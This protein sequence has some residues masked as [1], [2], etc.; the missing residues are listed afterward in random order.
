MAASVVVLVVTTAC[1][2]SRGAPSAFR[3]TSQAQASPSAAPVVPD[4]LDIEVRSLSS[5][6]MGDEWELKAWGQPVPRAGNQ[7]SFPWRDRT[8]VVILERALSWKVDFGQS[9]SAC[10][11]SPKVKTDGERLAWLEAPPKNPVAALTVACSG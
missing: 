7:A 9:I 6:G 3:A 1:G 10:Q 11:L 4:T 8:V 2:L 5:G